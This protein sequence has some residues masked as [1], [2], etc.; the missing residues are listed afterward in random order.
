MLEALKSM[1][2]AAFEALI[3]TLLERL[4]YG[5]V[6]RELRGTLHVDDHGVVITTGSF[7]KDARTEADAAGKAPIGLV[8]GPT[9]VELLINEGIGV[10]TRSVPVRKL[11]LAG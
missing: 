9:L 10:E 3:G 2:P 11:D 6:V 1:P 7:T 8:D 5:G 4:G